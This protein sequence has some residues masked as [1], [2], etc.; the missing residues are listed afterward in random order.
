VAAA[1]SSPTTDNSIVLEARRGDRPVSIS[2]HYGAIEELRAC[3]GSAVESA[4]GLLFGRYLEDSAVIEHCSTTP[5]AQA[6]IGIFRSQPAGWPGITAPDCKRLQASL[7]ATAPGALVLIVRTLAQ[8]PWS[9]TL[10]TVDPKRPSTAEAPL[11]EF[12]FDEYL[13]RNGWLTDLAPPAAPQPGMVAKTRSRQRVSWIA[14]AAAAALV[15]GGAAAYQLHWLPMRGPAEIVDVAEPPRPI[16]APLALKVARSF[17]EFEISWNRGAELVQ[18]ATAGTLTIH[19]GPVT[20]VVPVRPDQLH[21]GRIMYR[22]LAGVDSDF[23]LEIATSDGKTQAES[24]QAVAFDTAP[25]MALP[26][27]AAPRSPLPAQAA[28]RTDVSGASRRGL[29]GAP[30]TEPSPLR[31]V[32]PTISREVLGEMRNA[33]KVT[34]SVLVGIDAAGAVQTAKIVSSTGEPPSG[35]HI[36][37]A[38]LNAAR[39][40]KFRPATAGGKAVASELTLVF[41]F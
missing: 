31:R 23:R 17:D 38:S 7:P 27:A 9:A 5:R 13:L 2:I 32:S 25:S 4:T 11:L 8:R 36:R 24:V 12:P 22:P 26:V 20:R 40:W 1:Q 18:K 37:L 21:E 10:F 30:R 34:I 15:G 29:A 19:N 16:A 41:N 6:P 35:T 3:M 39:Q 28:D 14:I 33:G